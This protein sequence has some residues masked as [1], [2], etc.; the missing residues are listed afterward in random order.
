M[1]DLTAGFVGGRLYIYILSFLGGDFLHLDFFG[2]AIKT[3]LFPFVFI[4]AFSCV[5]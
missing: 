5:V 2:L 1:A 3:V 4:E